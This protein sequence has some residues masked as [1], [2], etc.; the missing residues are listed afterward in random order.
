MRK[1]EETHQNLA[2]VSPLVQSFLQTEKLFENIVE[3]SR[4]VDLTVQSTIELA[5]FTVLSLHSAR[6]T[7]VEGV[8]S[9]NNTSHGPASA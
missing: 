7:V 4:Q 2:R 9:Q 1:E 6:D 5:E 3:R 8:I